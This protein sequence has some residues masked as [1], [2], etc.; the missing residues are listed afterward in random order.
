MAPF[1]G[2]REAAHREPFQDLL[3]TFLCEETGFA[4]ISKRL[5]VFL[6]IRGHYA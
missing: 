2:G 4:I 1:I 6:L 3:P 5:P